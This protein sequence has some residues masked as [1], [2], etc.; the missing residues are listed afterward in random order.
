VRSGWW[1]FLLCLAAGEPTAADVAGAGERAYYQGDYSRA[2]SL[3]IADAN[4]G[5]AIAQSFLGYQYLYG[6][7]VPKSYEEAARWLRRAATQ[8][9]PSA[10]F[11]LGLLYDRGQGVAEDPVEAEMWLDLAAA[12]APSRKR[13]YWGSMRDAIAGKM[14]I[15]EV[16]EARRR[17]VAW[18]PVPER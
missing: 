18:F 10:Q 7:G 16:T 6:L 4:D 13:E 2:A 12:Q 17:A 5:K 15:D 11:F 8:G 3:L 9:E 1:F 14:T